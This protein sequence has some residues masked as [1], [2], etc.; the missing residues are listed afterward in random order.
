MMP[1]AAAREE[2]IAEAIEVWEEKVNRF[3]SHGDDYRLPMAFRN[4]ALEQMRVGNIRDNF[5]LSEAEKLSFEDLLQNV[6]EQARAKKLD[7]DAHKGKF[8][9]AMGP[10]LGNQNAWLERH[11]HVRTGG[12]S[13]GWASSTTVRSEEALGA[14]QTDKKG[15]KGKGK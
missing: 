9:F 10:N 6:E 8:G 13:E 3:A 1:K 5:E 4:V 12:G 15:K 2:Y 11:E 14:Y 7:K